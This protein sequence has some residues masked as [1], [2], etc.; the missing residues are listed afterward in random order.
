MKK[1]CYMLLISILISSCV[2]AQNNNKTTHPKGHVN[3]NGNGEYIGD[4]LDGVGIKSEDPKDKAKV[5]KKVK[6][7]KTATR[8][9]RS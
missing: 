2:F 1:L 8:R 6:T 5:V 3:T 7:K 4:T 9:R